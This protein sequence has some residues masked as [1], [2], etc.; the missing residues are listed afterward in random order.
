MY[1]LSRVDEKNFAGPQELDEAIKRAIDQGQQGWPSSRYDRLILALTRALN[2]Q[3]DAAS[4]LDE[5]Q[6]ALKGEQLAHG[7]TRAKLRKYNDVE[8]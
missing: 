1:D 5:A 6:R 4:K 3:N 8:E 7:R 2:E